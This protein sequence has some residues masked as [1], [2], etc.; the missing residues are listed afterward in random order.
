M[1]FLATTSEGLQRALELAGSAGLPIWCGSD[2][3]SDADYSKLAGRNVSRFAYPLHDA[4]AKTLQDA[5]DTIAE[6]HPGESVW[7]EHAASA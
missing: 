2:A 7:V 3:V 4:S 1:V 5:V 6:H